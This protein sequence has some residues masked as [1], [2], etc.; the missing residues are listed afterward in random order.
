MMMHNTY[1]SKFRLDI[2]GASHAPEVGIRIS[3]V[4][5]GIVLSESDFEADLAR[6]RAGNS[7]TTTRH[8]AD[9][10]TILS[11]IAEGVTTGEPIE[12]VFRN[13]DTRSSDYSQFEKHN[14]PSHIDFAARA[15][16]GEEIDLRGSGQFSGRMTVLL[17]AAGVVAKKILQGVEYTTSIIEIGGSRNNSEFA[18]IIAAA[19]ADGDSVGG[20]VECRAS[21]VEIGLGEPFFDSAESTDRKSV[22]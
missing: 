4:P 1:G 22:V 12:I 20:V 19:M 13:G 21:G 6:R 10:P 18:D 7:G 5:Q 3:G 17:V 2:W 14:R 8:E 15:K 11:G 16:Y 9:I